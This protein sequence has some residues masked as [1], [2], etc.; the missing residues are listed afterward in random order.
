MSL[1]KSSLDTSWDSSL[2]WSYIHTYGVNS[3]SEHQIAVDIVLVILDPC[4][5]NAFLL[6]RKEHERTLITGDRIQSISKLR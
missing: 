5:F 6:S 4:S 3:F 2:M 1:S